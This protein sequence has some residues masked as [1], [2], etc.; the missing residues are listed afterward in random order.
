MAQPRA[1]NGAR[2]RRGRIPISKLMKPLRFSQEEPG[3]VLLQLGVDL[4]R[5]RRSR[6]ELVL[7]RSAS[8]RGRRLVLG[9]LA[10]VLRRLRL[11]RRL[12]LA[13]PLRSRRPSVSGGSTAELSTL[14]SIF[15]CFS[16]QTFASFKKRCASFL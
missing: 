14:T 2:L 4:L 5:M 10:N 16:S 9:Q 1:S 6:A 7:E 11:R 13:R 15:G 12:A 3:D 8:A